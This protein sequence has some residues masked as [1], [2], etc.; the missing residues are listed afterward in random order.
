[1]A[2]K[3]PKKLFY[4]YILLIFITFF[5][6]LYLKYILY[7]KSFTNTKD[8]CFYLL[9]TYKLDKSLHKRFIH[10]KKQIDQS[11]NF[12]LVYTTGEYNTLSQ[13]DENNIK[14]LSSKPY[15][16]NI[17]LANGNNT[18][19][20]FGN[21][22][23]ATMFNKKQGFLS[24]GKYWTWN[25]A[26]FPEIIWSMNYLQEKYGLNEYT[27]STT[28]PN[29]AID[30]NSNIYIHVVEYDMLWTGNLIKILDQVRY[31]HPY[32]TYISSYIQPAATEQYIHRIKQYPANYYGGKHDNYRALWGSNSVAFV[33]Y[34]FA[35]LYDMYQQLA[36]EIY[37]FCEL[38][39]INLCVRNHQ[40]S[41]SNI[42]NSLLY[43]WHFL[44]PNNETKLE[45]EDEIY[46]SSDLHTIGKLFHPFK[47]PYEYDDFLFGESI[48]EIINDD[49]EILDTLFE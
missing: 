29:L 34:N 40:C 14:I 1:M 12:V 18:Q 48:D 35:L 3:I 16:I 43:Y 38:R 20:I 6:V 32:H 41:F 37:V 9:K 42:N 49:H 15:K 25:N 45:V 10:A 7:D 30:Y 39:A 33:R 47:D 26:D 27:L 17:Y 5:R 4:C 24:P 44:P 13:E 46:L 19:K 21:D 2:I 8:N 22:F 11:C 36:Q 28:R 31:Y 23:F